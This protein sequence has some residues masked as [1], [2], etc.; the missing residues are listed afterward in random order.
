MLSFHEACLKCCATFVPNLTEHNRASD[1]AWKNR[2]ILRE[3][4]R[5]IS[6]KSNIGKKRPILWLFSG[7]ISLQIDQFCADQTSVLNVFLTEVIIIL[8]F[9]QQYAPET[10]Q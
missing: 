8:L 10:N 7:Q 9:Q 3:F 1:K 2:P 5:Q 6:P 4:S